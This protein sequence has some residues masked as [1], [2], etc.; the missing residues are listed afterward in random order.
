MPAERHRGRV[1]D[2]DPGDM[3]DG[4]GLLVVGQQV[5]RDPAEAAQRDVD[6][7]Q[8]RG[9]GLVQQRQHHPEPGPGQPQAEQDRGRPA[10]PRAVPKSYWAHMPGSGTHGRNTRRRPAARFAFSCATARR[11]VR[12]DPA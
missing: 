10:D 12:S 1:A 7:G 9:L 5:G 3:L 4:H 8:H 6:R 2:R 11:V